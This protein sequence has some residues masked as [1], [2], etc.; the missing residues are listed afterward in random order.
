MNIL[1]LFVEGLSENCKLFTNT[2]LKFYTTILCLIMALTL[3]AEGTKQVSPTEDDWALLQ[4]REGFANYGTAGTSAGM[5]LE[6]LDAN[7]EVYIGLSMLGYSNYRNISNVSYDFRILDEMGNVVH[8]PFT[9]DPTNANGKIYDD[10]VAGPDLGNGVGYN[11]SDPMFRFSPGAI[12]TYCIEFDLTTEKTGGF[13]NEGIVWWDFT[14]TDAAGTPQLGRLFSENWSFRNPTDNDP[15][16]FN[17]PFKG[18]VF[19]LTDGGFVHEVDFEN[20]GFR[21]LTFRLAFNTSG[22]GMTGDNTIDRQSVDGIN[23]TNPQ[24]KIFL[25]DPDAGLYTEAGFGAIVSGPFLQGSGPCDTLGGFCVNFEVSQPG[26][27]EI[28]LDMDGMDGLYTP[29]TRDR[30]ILTRT[31][32]AGPFS[33][34]IPWDKKDGL[35]NSVDPFE[36]VP[37]FMKYSQGETHFMIHDLEYNNPGFTSKV[38]HPNGGIP[39]DLFYYDDSALDPVD[40]D[41]NLDL[42]N[43]PATG[44]NP[45]L[46]ELNGCPPPCH[47]W[48][49]NTTSSTIGFGESN[50]INTWWTG[51]V[52][53]FP[54]IIEV[55][56]KQDTLVVE[57]E[58]T[59]I[60]NGT[61]GAKGNFDVTFEILIKNMGTTIFDSL[62]V[63]DDMVGNF[64]ASYVGLVDGPTITSEVGIANLPNASAT[65]SPNLLDGVS[66]EMFPGDI[67]KIE[68]TVELNPNSSGTLS[69]LSN[70]AE[71]IVTNRYNGVI[72]DLS[73]DINDT[74]SN[75][76]PNIISFPKLG[77]AKRLANYPAP[78]AASG[79]AL[80]YDVTYEFIIE[81]IGNVAVEEVSLTDNIALQFGGAFVKIVSPPTIESSTTAATPGG[82]NATYNGNSE[83]ELL[84]STATLQ[85]GEQIVV[86]IVVEVSPYSAGAIYHPTGY[87]ANQASVSGLFDCALVT[88]LSDEGT[89]PTD[90][91]TPSGINNGTL[92]D[93]GSSNDPTLFPFEICG[94]G[95]DDDFDGMVDLDDDECEP[96]CSFSIILGGKCDRLEITSPLAGWTYEWFKNGTKIA[97]AT[98]EFYIPT[99]PEAGDYY[100]EINTAEGCFI[101]TNTLTISNCCEPTEP[102]VRG[103]Y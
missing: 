47:I 99:I 73:D 24:F 37:L 21:G 102:I 32:A 4:L 1:Q 80:N 98:A 94:N 97:G 7:E 40:N 86:Q 103:V 39:N 63:V 82:I 88:D 77:V 84:D 83:I 62:Q 43:N 14:V 36:G 29:N 16:I 59:K 72:T 96:D 20:S 79:T 45:T 67:I 50:T 68:F 60:T 70:Q 48:N 57:K 22:P 6:I 49:R 3:S 69:I 101:I 65:F 15:D 26:L 75:D 46:E 64:G 18:M 74:T 41:A 76:D 13:F 54:Q 8:G 42:D 51:S 93:T 34:C 9:V 53:V 85:S 12:G 61:S 5:C 23:A 11:V 89:D 28:I 30:I 52:I 2:Q 78:L 31:S 92:G 17:Q 27:V 81:N 71:A 25:N 87:L 95:E 33:D 38:I 35:G 19:V 44:T 58:V 90:T 56:C 55:L 66:G 10:V 100:V 91:E